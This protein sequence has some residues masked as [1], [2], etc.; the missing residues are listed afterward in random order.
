[1]LKRIFKKLLDNLGYQLEKKEAQKVDS[2]NAENFPEYIAEAEKLGIDVNDYLNEK[3]VNPTMVL[4]QTVFPYLKFFRNPVICEIG[5]GTG[6]H[7]KEIAKI[8]DHNDWTLYAVDHSPWVIN[9]LEKYFETCKNI[10]PIL[11]DG[12]RLPFHDDNFVDLIFGN[13]VFIELNLGTFYNYS[14]EFYRILKPGGYLIFDYIDINTNEGWKH[15][16]ENS[17][18]LGFCFTY[19]STE[20]IDKIFFSKGFDLIERKQI[21]KSTYVT[22]KKS[23]QAR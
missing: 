16:T 21:G 1:M 15:L 10:K 6:R 2:K 12:K 5:V 18:D 11:N 22:F 17:K 14:E 13:G 4:Q 3:W 19:H 7:T 9:F 8:L 23:S 20:T